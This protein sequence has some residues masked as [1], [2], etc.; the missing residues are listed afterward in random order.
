MT[1][2]LLTGVQQGVDTTEEGGVTEF[3]AAVFSLVPRG[4]RPPADRW[5]GGVIVF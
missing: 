3:P 2:R 1:D 4:H 5:S